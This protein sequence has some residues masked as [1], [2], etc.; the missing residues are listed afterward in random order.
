MPNAHS[1][2]WVSTIGRRPRHNTHAGFTLV[3]VLTVIAIVAM[4]IAMLLPGLR[5]AREQAK[6]MACQSNLHQLSIAWDVYLIENDGR[7]L[8]APNANINYGG[9]QG[10]QPAFRG[11]KPLNR[12]V[13]IEEV[14]DAG[15]EM[16]RCPSDEGSS[17]VR[18][19]SFAYHGTSYDTNPF[20]IGQDQTPFWRNR[21]NPCR[22]ILYEINKR[23]PGL[24]RSAVSA[25]EAKLMLLGD[26]GWVQQWDYGSTQE[27]YWHRRPNHYNVSFLDGHATFLHINKGVSLD[28]EYTL[29]PF[30]DLER[31]ACECQEALDDG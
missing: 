5:N 9:Q 17:L 21:Q 13:G 6:R 27:I 29:L 22:A 1:P 18:P 25:N 23:L 19:S 30:R 10:I 26:Y 12:F 24:V 7:F 11:S 2:A 8:Q 15:A 31:R 4:L 28:R 16:F 20:L 14:V 3:E